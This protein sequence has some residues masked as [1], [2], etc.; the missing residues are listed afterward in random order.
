MNLQLYLILFN[1]YHLIIFILL[2]YVLIFINFN[3]QNILINYQN[4]INLINFIKL[5][6][7]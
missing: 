5:F 4:F 3:L 7:Q 6:I 1:N 2:N